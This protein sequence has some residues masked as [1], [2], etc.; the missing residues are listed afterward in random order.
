M[1]S[2]THYGKSIFLSFFMGSNFRENCGRLT[3]ILLSFQASEISRFLDITSQNNPRWLI[4][5]E[6]RRGD[7]Y[8]P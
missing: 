7:T 2:V 8:R 4:A 5:L 3:V 1:C 6:F